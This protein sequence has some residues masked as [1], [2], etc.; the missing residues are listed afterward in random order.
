MCECMST[1]NRI[2]LLPQFYRLIKDLAV[3]QQLKMSNLAGTVHMYRDVDQCA[4]S[5]NIDT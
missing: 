1:H 2:I 5:L 4:L 3:G